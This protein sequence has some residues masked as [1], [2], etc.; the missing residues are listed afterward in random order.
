M[1]NQAKQR[2]G[3]VRGLRTCVEMLGGM[4]LDECAIAGVSVPFTRRGRPQDNAVLR[5]LNEV[6]KRGDPAELEGFCAALTD[7]VATADEH[8]DFY[9]MFSQLADTQ[10]VTHG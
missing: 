10:E 4:D 1:V 2:A 9:R 6:V 5:V 7:A 3:F 8:G